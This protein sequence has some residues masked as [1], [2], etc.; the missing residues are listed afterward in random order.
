MRHAVR[1]TAQPGI[2]ALATPEHC[3][4]ELDLSSGATP[5]ELVRALAAATVSLPTTSGVNVVVGFRPALWASL[6]PADAP[7][8]AEDWTEDLVGA[9][10]YRMP[11][12]PHD[13]WVWI[14]GA[15]RSAVFDTGRDVSRSVVGVANVATELTGWVYRNDRD[16]TGFIDGTEN[17]TALA[18]TEVACVPAGEPGAGASVLLFQKW[19]HD[20]E[21]WNCLSVRD[22]ELAMGRTKA[23]SVE[24]P[25]DEMP[26]S[27]HVSRTVIEVDGEEQEI[28]RRNVAYGSVSDHGTVF[29]GFSARQWR[30][31]EMLRRMAGAADGVRDAL[32]HYLT[33]LTGAYYTVPSVEALARFAPEDDDE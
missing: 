5:A 3:Y 31:M 28:F 22:Q 20:T 12:S 16:L 25:D 1:V 10:G 8:D 24:L 9:G 30:L 4:L 21:A 13:A 29:V 14:A 18:A 7:S 19:L 33:P 2:F 15:H 27:A 11:A 17:P 6:A 26:A 32:T 23:D